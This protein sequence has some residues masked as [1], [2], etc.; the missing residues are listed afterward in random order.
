MTAL[1]L[2][3]LAILNIAGI[4][5]HYC[6]ILGVIMRARYFHNHRNVPCN[7]TDTNTEGFLISS[8]AMLFF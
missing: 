8:D 4:I 7:G 5:P 3:L 2:M 6:I 1:P